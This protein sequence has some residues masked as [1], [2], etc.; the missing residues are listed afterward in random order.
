MGKEKPL[1]SSNTSTLTAS[2]SKSGLATRFASQ[3]YS[4]TQATSDITENQTIDT[5]A[6]LTLSSGKRMNLIVCVF[7]IKAVPLR[8]AGERRVLLLDL[9]SIHMVRGAESTII[10]YHPTKEWHT[11]SAKDL[12]TRMRLVGKSVYWQNIFRKTVDPTFVLLAILWH[13]LYAWDE[14]LETLYA[15]FCWL[16]SAT[17]PFSLA[18]S[19]TCVCVE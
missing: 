1:S 16:V 5:R 7:L 17:L 15:H 6:P 3:L 19:L 4:W 2:S 18:R 10:S 14:A 12:H 11:I 13:A 8:H 9:L